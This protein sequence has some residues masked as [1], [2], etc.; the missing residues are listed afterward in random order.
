MLGTQHN[1]SPGLCVPEAMG[2]RAGTDRMGRVIQLLIRPDIY[3]DGLVYSVQCVYQ[4]LS[5]AFFKPCPQHDSWAR[6]QI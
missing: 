3:K 4:N 6:D 2:F 1:T 5:N